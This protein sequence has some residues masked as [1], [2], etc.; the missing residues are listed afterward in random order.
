MTMGNS[1]MTPADFISRYRLYEGASPQAFEEGDCAVS[2]ATD[3]AI[4]KPRGKAPIRLAFGKMARWVAADYAVRFV[5]QGGDRVEIGAVGRRYEELVLALKQM[6]RQHK[7]QALL[8]EETLSSGD[9]E[10][11]AYMRRSSTGQDLDRD[12]CSIRIMRS[13]LAVLPDNEPPFVVP[14]GEVDG[15][16]FESDIHGS[17]LSLGLQGKIALVRF[18][19]RTEAVHREIGEGL[20]ALE[21]RQAKLF[22]DMVPDLGAFALRR[23]GQVLRDGVAVHR[24][25]VEE[26]APGA[27]DAIWRHAMLDPARRACAEDLRERAGDLYLAIKEL[28]HIRRASPTG[29]GAAADSLP[30]D[31]SPAEEAGATHQFLYFFTVGAALVLEV[32][33]MTGSATYVFRAGD[34]VLRRATDISRAL[35][36]M[37]FRREPIY[38]PE[39]SLLEGPGRRYLEA[40]RTLGYL[41]EVRAAFVGRAVHTSAIAWRASLDEALSRL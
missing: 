18:A 30:D 12:E 25:F 5:L 11:G 28:G 9:W 3:A 36:A 41:R 22:Q 29:G 17:V 8:L 10:T 38:L 2:M 19:R 35:A 24:R 27:W 39:S 34:N 31:D 21:A 23:L 7:L 13:S 37:Q 32:P 33:S 14:Y 4:I 1:E 15:F 26:A 20:A 40:V 6:Q 16:S